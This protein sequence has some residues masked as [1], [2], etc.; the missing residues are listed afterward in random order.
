MHY[1]VQHCSYN[2]WSIMKLQIRHYKVQYYTTDFMF[3]KL[4]SQWDNENWN[5][6]NPFICFIDTL[7]WKAW[8]QFSIHA[9]QLFIWRLKH[10][11]YLFCLNVSEQCCMEM[12][13]GYWSVTLSVMSEQLCSAKP[14]T[15]QWIYPKIHC[16]TKHNANTE[17]IIEFLTCN[18]ICENPT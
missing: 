16:K 12:C 11:A 4:W 15:R 18:P 17:L 6:D 3:Q 1:C 9:D 13:G 2:Y 5:T 7:W 8:D 10:S 14:H